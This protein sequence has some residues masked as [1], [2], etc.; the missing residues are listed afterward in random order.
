MDKKDKL[1]ENNTIKN[2]GLNIIQGNR[3][4]DNLINKEIK[5]NF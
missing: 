2:N 1:D 5:D 4:K 3:N